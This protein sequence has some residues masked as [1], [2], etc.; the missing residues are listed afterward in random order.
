M[1][2]V[3]HAIK[4]SDVSDQSIS[5]GFGPQL[6]EKDYKTLTLW[7]IQFLI[8]CQ[9]DEFCEFK[10]EDFKLY[11]GDHLRPTTFALIGDMVLDGY[12]G[13]RDDEIYGTM[14][15]I[16]QPLIEFYAGHS[17]N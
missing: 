1:T 15:I 6:E 5:L 3:I 16:D 14:I 7:I 12:L 11:A 4:P 10:L 8:E 13:I 17:G 2:A 9:G